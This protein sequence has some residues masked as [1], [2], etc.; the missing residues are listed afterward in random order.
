MITRQIDDNRTQVLLGFRSILDP[1]A[2]PKEPDEGLLDYVLRAHL[3]VGE[4]SGETD[5]AHCLFLVDPGQVTSSIEVDVRKATGFRRDDYEP[6]HPSVGADARSVVSKLAADAQQ[7]TDKRKAEH[8]QAVQETHH[9]QH[10]RHSHDLV[11][12]LS[13]H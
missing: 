12:E 10:A 6:E 2:R 3:V 8:V 5:E 9:Q 4:Q 7:T 13:P 1:M 11:L